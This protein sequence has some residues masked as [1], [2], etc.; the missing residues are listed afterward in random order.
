MSMNGW[1]FMKAQCTKR[2]YLSQVSLSTVALFLLVMACSEDKDVGAGGKNDASCPRGRVKCGETCADLFSSPDNCGACGLSCSSS[3]VCSRGVCATKCHSGSEDC[4]RACVSTVSD[5]SHCGSCFSQCPTGL[6]CGLS[7][8]SPECPDGLEDC[9]GGCL[10]TDYHP[11]HC[12]ACNGVCASGELCGDGVCG[13]ACP[14]GRTECDDGCVD[15]D[16]SVL[17]C[18]ECNISCKHGETCKNG[19]CLALC[20]DGK[21]VDLQ[22]DDQN[23]GSCGFECI[24]F[25][26][27]WE[28]NSQC[29]FGRCWGSEMIVAFE[30]CETSLHDRGADENWDSDMTGQVVWIDGAC[31]EWVPNRPGL[32][33]MCYMEERLCTPGARFNVPACD[34][35]PDRCF[36]P[37]NYPGMTTAGCIDKAR[38]DSLLTDYPDGLFASGGN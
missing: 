33:S 1:M 11:L 37:V 7:T 23:C 36:W 4:G 2:A 27:S 20:D 6:V 22:N 12:G 13:G 16:T 26:Y 25:P 17:H 34:C 24:V 14:H 9:G 38:F 28:I 21:Q 3:E 29:K 8:C 19:V 15:L 32:A 30:E 10:S 5:N 35:G 18:G 31:A